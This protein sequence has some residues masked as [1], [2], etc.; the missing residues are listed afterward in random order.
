M[1]PEMSK[2]MSKLQWLRQTREVFVESFG[3]PTGTIEITLRD[4]SGNS[5][6]FTLASEQSANGS[7][8]TL[9]PLEESFVR[10]VGTSALKGQTIAR[11]VGENYASRLK[12]ILSNLVERGLLQTTPEGYRVILSPPDPIGEMP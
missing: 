5:L 11:R 8:P 4:Q 7:R 1:P 9:S 12:I 6:T 10:A 3:P 2:A